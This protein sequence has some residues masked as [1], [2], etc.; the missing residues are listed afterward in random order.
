MEWTQTES[1]WNDYERL[2]VDA[3]LNWKEGIHRCGRHLSESLELKGRPNPQYVV[4]FQTCLGCKAEAEAEHRYL[5][6]WKQGRKETDTSPN[7][8]GWMLPRVYSEA[9]AAE[10]AKNQGQKRELEE[11]PWESAL[12]PLSSP[13]T[14]GNT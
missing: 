10:V 13:P 9:E 3:Y 7:P 4:G 2:L 1:V 12:S 8:L 11:A 6:K 14:Q 5:Q